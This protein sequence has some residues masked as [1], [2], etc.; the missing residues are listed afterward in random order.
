MKVVLL[1][2]SLFSFLSLDVRSAH[3]QEPTLP[4]VFVTSTRTETP[5]QDVTTS[6][7]VIDSKDIENQQAEMVLET[8]LGVPGLEVVQ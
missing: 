2:L 8:L 5:L 7:P 4:P 3:G 1:F 6:A